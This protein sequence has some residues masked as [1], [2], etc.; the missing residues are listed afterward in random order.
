MR[1]WILDFGFSIGR[2]KRRRPSFVLLCAVLVALSYPVSAQQ[3]KKVAR[4]GYLGTNPANF[5]GTD[6]KAFRERLRE[7]DYAEGQNIILEPRYWEG[8]VERLPDLVA[9]LVRLKC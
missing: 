9:D 5:S 4:I 7:L 1:F 8:K 3:P 6:M 2:S